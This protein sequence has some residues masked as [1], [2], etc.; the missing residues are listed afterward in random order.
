MKSYF[1][2]LKQTYTEWNDDHAPR[3]AAAMAYYTLFSIAPVLV[4]A[5]AV[6]GLVFGQDAVQGQLYGQVRGFVGD[7]GAEAIQGL[8]ASASKQSSGI[9]A[10]ILG[11]GTLLLG[12]AGV[13]GQ[14]QEALNAIWG[15][16][17][18]PDLG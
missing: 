3:L 18:R 15:V 2:L 7:T 12:A 4:I 8:V 10:S 9:L 13:F 11:V 1:D 17:P 14:L 16:Q 6:A 5:I